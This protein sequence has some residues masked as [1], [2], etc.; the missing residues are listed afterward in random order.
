MND[1]K[2]VPPFTPQER[3]RRKAIYSAGN[4]FWLCPITG[5]VLSASFGDDKALCGCG[6]TN[7]A[8]LKVSPK[9]D[10]TGGIA[11]GLSHHIKRHME[12]STV[13]AFLEQKDRAEAARN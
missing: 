1:R 7:P 4:D 5:R 3:A 12:P 11:G 10:E 8:V 6:K 9:A 2:L 13:D